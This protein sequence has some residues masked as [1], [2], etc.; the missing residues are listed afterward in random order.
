MGQA[1]LLKNLS[2]EGAHCLGHK[3]DTY[4]IDREGKVEKSAVK[5]LAEWWVEIGTDYIAVDG[6]NEVSA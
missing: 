6:Q 5:Y 3:F 2:I 1:H 4:T